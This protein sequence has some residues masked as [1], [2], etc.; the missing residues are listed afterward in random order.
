MNAKMYVKEANYLDVKRVQ[1]WPQDQRK[2]LIMGPGTEKTFKDKETGQER[3]KIQIP[4]AR[5]YDKTEYI[6]TPSQMALFDL[7]E[8]L[9]T[10]DTEK[11]VGAVVKPVIKQTSYGRDTLCATVIQKP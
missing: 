4:V 3:V 2:I 9:E 11:W 1:Q 8:E 10:W 7:A 6:W 5:V